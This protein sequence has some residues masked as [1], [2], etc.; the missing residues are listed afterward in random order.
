MLVDSGA[1]VNLL[2]YSL[3]KKL[4]DMDEELIKTSMTICGVGGGKPIP[5]K[6]VASKELTIRNKMLAT[7]FLLQKCKGAT[8]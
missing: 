1:I 6:G 8:T 2:S 7:A 4:G 3:Y 5:T